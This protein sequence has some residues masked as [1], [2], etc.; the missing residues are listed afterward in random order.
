MPDVNKLLLHSTESAGWPSYP[1]FQPTLTF[2]PWQPRG[3]RWRQHLPINGSASTLSN[4]G[5][6]RTNRANVCQIEIVGYC[7][8]A[9]RESSAYLTKMSADAQQELAEFLAWIHTEWSVT[10]QA[11]PFK[12]YPA[13]YGTNNGV[14]LTIQQFE[15]YDGVCGHQHAPGNSH[16]DPGDV[17]KVGEIVAEA[18][19]ITGNTPRVLRAL[20]QNFR[21][22][23][24]VETETNRTWTERLPHMINHLTKLKPAVV[25]GQEATVNQCNDLMEAFPNWTYSGGV[26]F[27]N[28]PIFWDTLLLQAEE[29]TLLEKQYPSGERHRYM[30][31]IRLQHRQLEWGAWF[32]TCHLAANGADEPRSAMLRA[33]QM[34]A[35]VADVKAWISAHPHPEDEKPNLIMCGDLN[36]DLGDDAGVRKVAYDHGGWKGLRRRLPL[37]KISGDT[38]RSFNGWRETSS[39]PRDSKA[40]DEIFTSGV[41]LEDAALR[42]TCTDVYP[43]YVSDHNAYSA[44]ILIN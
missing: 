21:K 25:G 30:T 16:G 18:K 3:K 26:T 23:T 27:G 7:D 8:P 33:L 39:L 6:Y 36:D 11:L 4:A 32:G 40:I 38:Y 44:D 10:L 31:L 2:N 17:L 29:G 42:R 1:T 37:D 9:R 22:S 14:R 35:I 20:T 19:R 28:C 41:G 34:A 12:A 24:I 43:I 15:N 5:T 13:S